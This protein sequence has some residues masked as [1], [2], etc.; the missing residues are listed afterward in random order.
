MVYRPDRALRTATGMVAH[1]L[2][3]ETF[4][5]G[6]DPQQTFRESIAPRPGMRKLVWALRY[7]VDREKGEAQASFFGAIASRAVYRR[8]WGCVL[9]HDHESIPGPS[10]IQVVPQASNHAD[11]TVVQPETPQLKAAVDAAFSEPDEAPHRWTKAVVIIQ[12]GRIVAE[13]YA[14]GYG[15]DTP[16]LGFSMTKS[17]TNALVGILVRQGKLSVTRPASIAAWHDADDPR[18]RITLEDLMRMD[19]GLALDETGS[20]FDPSNQMFYDEADMA[21]YAARAAVV[22][23]P[24][25]R[26]FYSSAST[27]LVSRIVRDAVGGSGE[28]VQDFAFRELFAPLGMRHVTFEMDATGT[29][30][31]AHYL[32]ASARDWARFGQLYLDDGMVGDKRL[33]PEG[34]VRWSSEPTLGTA[35]GAG[36]WTNRGDD[37]SAEHRRKIGIPADA[38]FAFG[39]LGQRI[40]V[41]PSERLVIVRMARAHQPYGDMAGFEQLVVDTV[42]SLHR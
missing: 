10:P 36:W 33:L 8:G 26:W 27:H 42:V 9:V 37:E 21:A 23:A 5:A 35:Y 34:W 41:I 39:N 11:S 25:T 32:L 7:Q 6:L 13:R 19:S 2:C 30:I 24:R 12:D 28:A 4:V 15:I 17:V 40:A 14:P 31:G 38:M 1:D 16:I 22:A 18:R 29:P 20:G 3:S